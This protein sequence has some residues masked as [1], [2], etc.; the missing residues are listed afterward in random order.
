MMMLIEN[1]TSIYKLVCLNAK[2]V[3]LAI[4]IFNRPLGGG[5][6]AVG[7]SSSPEM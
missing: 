3:L 7:K 5:D 2:G 6:P 1:V 4:K